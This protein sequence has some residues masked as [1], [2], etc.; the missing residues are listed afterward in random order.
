MLCVTL[1]IFG[2]PVP[3]TEKVPPAF[4]NTGGLEGRSWFHTLVMQDS[5]MERSGK[6]SAG[7]PRC[8]CELESPGVTQGLIESTFFLCL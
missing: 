6:G 4:P 7:S 5:G 3:A 1:F 8:S 2:C